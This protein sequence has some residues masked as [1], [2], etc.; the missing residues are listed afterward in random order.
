MQPAAYWI[1]AAKRAYV[2]T[3]DRRALSY[4]DQFVE[5][6]AA[7]PDSLIDSLDIPHWLRDIWFDRLGF[8]GQD[9]GGMWGWSPWHE[10]VHG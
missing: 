4:A 10:P 9:Q 1:E 7:S 8:V 5:A 3:G 6:E 2:L